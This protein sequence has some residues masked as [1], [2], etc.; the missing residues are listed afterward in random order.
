MNIQGMGSMQGMMEMMGMGSSQQSAALTDDQKNTV[1]SILSKYRDKVNSLTTT[2][3]QS[4]FKQFQDAGITPTRGLKEAIES[5]GFNADDLR[6]KAFGTQ[7]MQGMPP[8][9]P[10][11]GGTSSST[12]IE[13]TDDQ[14]KTVASILSKY[15]SSNLTATTAQSFFKDLNSAGITPMKGL[16][17]AIE[18]AG[19]DA[20]KLRSLAMP[21]ETSQNMFWAS[22][23]SSTTVNKSS[24]QT[25]KSILSQ[26]DLSSLSTDQETSLITQLSQS[27]L[28]QS[29]ST[30][31]LGA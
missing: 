12:S 23:N 4:I 13:L 30:L 17:E 25:L 5:A 7:G 15:D 9:P 29:G 20:E 27:G 3:A 18:S 24:L 19:F 28:L 26:Y 16:K 22:Q 31:N 21:Q 6:T 14:K 1:A 10:Q 8:P 2:D 11:T